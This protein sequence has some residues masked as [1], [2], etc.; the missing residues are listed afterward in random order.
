MCRDYTC[1]G[2]IL[3]DLHALVEHFEDH[4]V[5]V[6]ESPALQATY[7]S[8]SFMPLD[9]ID[10]MDLDGHSS[11]SSSPSLPDT[12]VLPFDTTSVRRS[13]LYPSN[14]TSP[15]V[16]SAF[17]RYSGYTEFSSM[18]P[19]TMESS[20]PLS[21][22]PSH[23]KSCLPPA[24]LNTPSPMTT[25]PES[26]APSTT[27]SRPSSSLL[28][29][30]PFR[31]PKEGCNKSYKQ[32]NGLKYHIQHGSCNFTPLDPS[33]E[34]MDDK[35][36][37]KKLRP[38]QCQVP[39]CTRRYKNMNG[40]R[41]HYQHSGAHGAIGLALI[42]SGQHEGENKKV[43]SA[44]STIPSSPVTPTSTAPHTP[45]MTPSQQPFFSMQDVMMN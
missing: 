21:M 2:I 36:A 7:M 23:S 17:N 29:S 39:P 5:V 41:Y 42:A 4:H 11:G 18:L 27:L 45:V 25:P 40:L 22:Y 26:P 6:V 15:R 32:A 43:R 8:S 35:E 28:L 24:L 12:P 38:F 31:C 20:P 1:C 9:P 34:G 44:P 13:S 33:L 16:E 19:G 3:N 14:P 10:D 37:E 30:K